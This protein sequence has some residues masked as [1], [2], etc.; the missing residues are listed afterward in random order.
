[1]AQVVEQLKTKEVAFLYTC[2]RRWYQWVSE[3]HRHCWALSKMLRAGFVP[4]DTPPAPFLVPQ[5]HR[6]AWEGWPGSQM[7]SAVFHAAPV[8]CCV[9]ASPQLARLPRLSRGAV[10]AVCQPGVLLWGQAR[11]SMA[12][13]EPHMKPRFPRSVTWPDTCKHHLQF[14]PVGN[15]HFFLVV[16]NLPLL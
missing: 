16:Y 1:M 6:A 3:G 8:T 13:Q 11:G 10:A 7:L 12:K 2:G 15:L 4:S 9:S 14:A 5:K